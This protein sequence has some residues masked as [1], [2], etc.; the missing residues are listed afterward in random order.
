ML[1]PDGT[2]VSESTVN[3]HQ[4]VPRAEEAGDVGHSKHM[5]PYP[6]GCSVL[7]DGQLLTAVQ[8]LIT[9]FIQKADDNAESRSRGQHPNPPTSE[10]RSTLVEP[11]PPRELQNLLQFALPEHGLGRSGFIDMVESKRP[12]RD[13][14]KSRPT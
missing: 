8:H 3:G 12:S 13:G 14:G 7:I 1:V 10:P 5:I 4:S 6:L 9:A 11:H 2:G